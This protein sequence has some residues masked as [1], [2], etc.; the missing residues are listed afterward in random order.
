[1]ARLEEQEPRQVD[2]WRVEVRLDAEEHGHSLG[3]RLRTLDLDD[4][5]RK[6]LGGSVIVTREGPH[7]FLYAWHEP[8]AR[9]AERV[10]RDLLEEEGLVAEVSLT[11][12]HPVAEAWRPASEP[13]PDTAVEQAAE[14]KRHEDAET[15][16]LTR[17]GRYGW[18]VVVELPSVHAT[19]DFANE[20][21]RRDLPVKRRWKYVLVGALTENAAIELGRELEAEAPEGAAIGIRANP[22]DLP[23]PVFIQL[24]SLKPGVLRDLGI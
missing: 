6:R 13:L 12:W 20:L 8:S 2:E 5:A 17:S 18:E 1:M 19:V 16:E 4:E 24:G 7:M 22:D 21:E 14:A 11:R 3:E 9:E 10:I 15:R 23:L